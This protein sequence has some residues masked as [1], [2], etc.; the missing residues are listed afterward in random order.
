MHALKR[1]LIARRGYGYIHLPAS[2]IAERVYWCM[3]P[4]AGSMD[5]Q[6]GKQ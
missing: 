3:W 6:R 1:Q 5:L 2:M 4:E